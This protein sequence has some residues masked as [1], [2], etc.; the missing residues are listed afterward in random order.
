MKKKE[1]YITAQEIDKARKSGNY[2]HGDDDMLAFELAT[3]KTFRQM[4]KQGLAERTDNDSIME[5]MGVKYRSF[6][7]GGVKTDKFEQFPISELLGIETYNL[8]FLEFNERSQ[9]SEEKDK[10][11]KWMSQNKDNISG[12]CSFAYLFGGYGDENSKDYIHGGHAYAI[13]EFE[14]GKDIVI[15]DP[16]YSDYEIKVPWKI[17]N[18]MVQNISFSFKDHNT[19]E[20]LQNVLPKNIDNYIKKTKEYY[21]QSEKE[22]ADKLKEI[23]KKAKNEDDLK[24][25]IDSELGEIKPPPFNE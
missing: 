9:A 10:L 22:R 21:K 13:K 3:E 6:I 14:Y 18:E 7:F 8:E 24:A 2:S 4:V 17:F 11:F 23:M 5:K 19:K 12:T 16:H 1:I 15:S 25:L 20:R